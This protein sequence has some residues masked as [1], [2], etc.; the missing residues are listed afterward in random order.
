MIKI[1]KEAIITKDYIEVINEMF[2]YVNKKGLEAAFCDIYADDSLSHVIM[3]GGKYRDNDVQRLVSCI[4]E[5]YLNK[6]IGFRENEKHE[7]EFIYI[8]DEYEKDKAKYIAEK[9]AWCAKYGCN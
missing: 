2:D 3:R 1:N 7:Y 4:N 6:I 5:K 9:A 8:D